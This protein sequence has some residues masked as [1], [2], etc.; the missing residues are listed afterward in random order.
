MV[1]AADLTD[2]ALSSDEPPGK[3][4]PS[5]PVRI[6]QPGPIVSAPVHASLS[7]LVHHPALL[8]RLPVM[9]PAFNAEVMQVQLQAA[10]FGNT[11]PACII[12]SCL[13]GK[14]FYY[15]EEYCLLQYA[16]KMREGE[17]RYKLVVNARLFKDH[18]R[19]EAYFQDRLAP[20]VKRTQGRPEFRSVLAPAAVLAEL[21]IAV[22]IF[23]ID[24]QLPTLVKATD[25]PEM[26]GLVGAI[27]TGLFDRGFVLRGMR[28]ELAHYGRYERCVL[29]YWLDGEN[30]RTGEAQT[31]LAYGK[32]DGGNSHQLTR[33]ATQALK[34]WILKSGNSHLFRVPE[35]YG[36]WPEFKILLMEALPGEASF[37]RML[38]ERVW[39]KDIQQQGGPSL[40]EAIKTAARVAASFHESGISLGPDRTFSDEIA[41]LQAEVDRIREVLPEIGDRLD[42]WLKVIASAG[43]MRPAFPLRFS[44]GDFTYTQFIYQEGVTGLVDFDNVC[45][46]EPALDLGQFLAYLRFNIRKEELPEK[47]FP[48][49]A[50]DKLNTVFLDEYFAHAGDWA[51]DKESLR[52]RIQLYELLSLV[53]LAI[54]SWQKLKG[55]R[56][57]HVMKLLEEGMPCLKQTR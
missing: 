10:L 31:R 21:P 12:E 32:V 15:S 34:D 40:E 45:Q 54:H 51:G 38:R 3:V 9:N 25:L 16:L 56:L 20:L 35:I 26:A 23:P 46:A 42:A 53:R 8:E 22:S 11:E 37:S 28:I 49:G 52:T 24:G 17:R 57:N 33:A 41:S 18:A 19:A 14:G 39:L 48:P 44:H 1:K 5:K 29:R 36:Y 50:L 43:S 30:E 7:D 6:A 55:S 47:P 4:F 2:P 13:P 27:E